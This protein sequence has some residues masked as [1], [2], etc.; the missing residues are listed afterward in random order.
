VKPSRLAVGLVLCAAFSCKVSA[1]TAKRVIVIKIDGL[2]ADFL[3][4]YID[5]KE[6]DDGRYL[7]PWFHHIFIERGT[8]IQNFYVRGISLSAPSWSMLE[9]GQH[10]AIRGN[11]EFDRYYG[12]VYDYLN[13]FPFYV[14]NARSRRVDMPAVEV[15]DE[16]GIPLLA[17]Q[18]PFASRYQSMELFQRGVHWQTLSATLKSRIAGPVKKVIDEWQKGFEFGDAI[19]EQQEREL[20]AKLSD[21]EVLYLGYFS[22]E[23]DHVAHLTNDKSTQ[24]N[25]LRQIDAMLGRVWRA[26]GS[27]PLRNQTVLALVSDHG[28]NSIPG[29]YSQGYDLVR[30]FNSAEG[31]GHHVVTNCH[32]RGEYKLRGLDPFVSWVETPSQES[33]YLAGEKEYPTALL[34]LD[35]NERAS[36]QLRNSDLNEIQILLEQLATPDVE[37]AEKNAEAA[38]I[39]AIVERN[40]ALWSRTAEQLREELAALERAIGN[41]QALVAA[42]KHAWSAED[43]TSGTRL[44]SM[45]RAATLGEWLGEQRGYS[46]YLSALDRLL[47]LKAQDLVPLRVRVDTLIPKRAMGE[48]NSMRQLANYV[49]GPKSDGMVFKEDG[50][51]D[52]ERSFS[53]IE[54][55]SA[56]A[57]VRVR[58]SV[59]AALGS[60]PI[61]FIAERTP[62]PALVHVLA[63]SDQ[64]DS[65]AVFLYR[66][67]DHGALL[68]KQ[69]RNGELWLRY[70]PVSVAEQDRGGE[71]HFSRAEW[72]VGMPLKLFEDPDLPVACYRSAWLNAWHSERDWLNA[73]HRT[74]YSNAVIGLDEYFRR[75]VTDSVPPAFRAAGDEQDWRLLQRFTVRHRA[76]VE[77]DMLILTNY[78]WNFNVRNPNPG[79]NYGSFFRIS[80]PFSCWR[81]RECLRDY[82][83]SGHMT[84]SI[85]SPRWR[86]SSCDQSTAIP[87][88]R[89]PKSLPPGTESVARPW[90]SSPIPQQS[91]VR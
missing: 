78:G 47:S 41:Q 57:R 62:K 26:I 36:V 73:T 38:A 8:W 40:R 23:F 85:S 77:P 42:D 75:W 71:L 64:P 4:R 28:L 91:S 19:L 18:F 61:D 49:C 45:R 37:K 29:V 80:T 6:P 39:L 53:R 20:I 50:S 89:L 25:Q 1:E 58:N 21:P 82:A 33:T 35:G 81:E 55:F 2:P 27:S 30:F 34:D 74:R 65:D 48:P 69:Y 11:A 66:D 68:L 88:R 44:E 52:E 17:N 79:G 83:S 46:E 60:A 72:D 24:L 76:A 54:Y 63:K 87:R 5:S 90:Q 70:V 51:L 59:Q 84:A 10:Q 13:F 7:L 22:G 32:P 16:S 56:L 67:P 86:R 12:R 43:R 3:E 31:G 9:S 15:M 14:G